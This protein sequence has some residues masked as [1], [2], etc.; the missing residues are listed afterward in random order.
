MSCS[1]CCPVDIFRRSATVKR[2]RTL[3]EPAQCAVCTLGRV[4]LR[5]H[6]YS[7]PLSDLS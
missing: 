3:K 5:I 2:L 7:W 6:I 4:V 1:F